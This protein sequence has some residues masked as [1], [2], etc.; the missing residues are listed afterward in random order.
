[1]FEVGSY[2][3]EADKEAWRKIVSLEFMS[4]DESCAEEGQEV[5]VSKPLPWQSERVTH[6]KQTL[7]EAALKS[8]SPLARRQMKPRRKGMPSSRV[9]PIGDFPAWVFVD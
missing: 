7:D 4:S 5:L 2:K 8:K 9:R 3:D 6:F 1:M